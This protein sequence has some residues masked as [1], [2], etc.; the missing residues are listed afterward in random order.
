M[1]DLN[2]KLVLTSVYLKKSC[3]HKIYEIAYIITIR[4][5]CYTK[6][7]ILYIVGYFCAKLH[8]LLK[9]VTVQ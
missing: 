3:D 7:N 8:V 1:I 6:Y 2:V 4:Y 9:Q 5:K